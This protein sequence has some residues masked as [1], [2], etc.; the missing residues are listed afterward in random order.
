M[1]KLAFSFLLLLISFTTFSQARTEGEWIYLPTDNFEKNDSLN[2]YLPIIIKTYQDS[3]ELINF[4]GFSY[5][6]SI[7]NHELNLE[8]VDESLKLN[9]ENFRLTFLPLEN[10]SQFK[11][12]NLKKNPSEWLNKPLSTGTTNLNIILKDSLTNNVFQYPNTLN[13]EHSSGLKDYELIYFYHKGISLLPDGAWHFFEY[14]DFHF[15][16]L[17]SGITSMSQWYFIT[18]NTSNSLKLF[19][20]KDAGFEQLSFKVIEAEYLD[21]KNI[22]GTWNITKLQPR[23]TRRKGTLMNMG[24]TVEFH[25]PTKQITNIAIE[26][27]SVFIS[28]LSNNTY[29]LLTGNKVLD[30]GSWKHI[31]STRLIEIKSFD[32]ERLSLFFGSKY[33]HIDK[34]SKNNVKIRSEFGLLNIKDEV[35]IEPARITL[36]KV[37]R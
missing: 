33:L 5:K 19:T 6:E 2:T 27:D 23:K 12:P 11:R 20:S 29:Q 36:R 25:D 35:L 32:K 22:L 13:K 28:F 15:L 3:I 14:Q 21:T 7:H 31:E 9:R 17:Q 4:N 10:Y 8:I 37:K 26:S 1:N 24:M 34:I 18:D 16:I 30:E